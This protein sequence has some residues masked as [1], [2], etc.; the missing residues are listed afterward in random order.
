MNYLSDETPAHWPRPL[1]GS[2]TVYRIEIEGRPKAKLEAAFDFIDSEEQAIIA[3][4]MRAINAI[5]DVVAAAA[6]A[7]EPH[8]VPMSFSGHVRKR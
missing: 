6:G 1:L 2:H 7:L 8:Q 4:A 5:P 3:T